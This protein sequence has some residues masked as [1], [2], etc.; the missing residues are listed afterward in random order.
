M[1]EEVDSLNMNILGVLGSDREVFNRRIIFDLKLKAK[2]LDLRKQPGF[3]DRLRD[4]TYTNS[5]V[6]HLLAEFRGEKERF[7]Q[8]EEKYKRERIRQELLLSVASTESMYSILKATAPRNAQGEPEITPEYEQMMAAMIADSLKS[9]SS[10]LATLQKWSRVFGGRSSALNTLIEDHQNKET[11]LR[12]KF[13]K[14][15]GDLTGDELDRLVDDRSFINSIKIPNLN[16]LDIADIKGDIKSI[17]N[18]LKVIWLKQY[19]WPYDSFNL[20]A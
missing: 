20:T 10:S 17:T 12:N 14:L 18:D 19:G 1:S 6:E 16:V 9:E 13:G 15:P 11:E 3:S 5:L 2:F 4:E 7:N 8:E